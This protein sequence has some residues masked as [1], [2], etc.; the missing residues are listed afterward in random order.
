MKIKE[1]TRKLAAGYS[2]QCFEVVDRTDEVSNHTYGKVKLTWFEEIFEEYKFY[3]KYDYSIVLRN[4][5]GKTFEYMQQ[6]KRAKRNDRISPVTRESTTVL[7][8]QISNYF[9]GLQIFNNRSFFYS[10]Q[11]I[12]YSQASQKYGQHLPFFSGLP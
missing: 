3:V 2:K 8:L 5:R 4:F 6:I 12:Y 9:L 1:Q 7:S 10:I 11:Q